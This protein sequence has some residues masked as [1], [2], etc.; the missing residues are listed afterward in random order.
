MIVGD[1]K[2][3]SH[4]EISLHTIMQFALVTR[5]PLGSSEMVFELSQGHLMR[6]YLCRLLDY[7]V[8]QGAEAIWVWCQDP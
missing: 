1:L 3:E 2:G 7:A 5:L 8:L 4:L 6:V